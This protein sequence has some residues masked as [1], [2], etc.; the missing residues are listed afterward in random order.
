MLFRSRNTYHNRRSKLVKQDER[1]PPEHPSRHCH[2]LP[3]SPGYV[4]AVK[5][6][7][8]NGIDAIRERVPVIDIDFRITPLT[9]VQ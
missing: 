9:T 8:H 2:A 5:L 6:P 1:V 7:G 3:L 4:D